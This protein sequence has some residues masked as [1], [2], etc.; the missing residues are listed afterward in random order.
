[1][2]EEL[3]LDAI[4]LIRPEPLR[5]KDGSSRVVAVLADDDVSAPEVLEVVGEGADRANDGVRVPARLV[6]DALALHGALP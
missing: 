6:L 4:E 5:R 1:V 3:A 2:L